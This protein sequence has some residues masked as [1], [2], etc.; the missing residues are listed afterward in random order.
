MAA[1]NSSQFP[2][3][4]WYSTPHTNIGNYVFCP[5]SVLFFFFLFVSFTLI[6]SIAA[7]MNAPFNSP[8]SLIE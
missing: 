6:V 3:K 4:A 1:Q 7:S 8:M 5:L 2:Y